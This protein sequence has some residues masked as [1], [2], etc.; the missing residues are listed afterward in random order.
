M[1]YLSM[2]V[3]FI[4]IQAGNPTPM[5]EYS[6]TGPFLSKEMCETHG[7]NLYSVALTSK[8]F[9]VTE[10]KCIINKNIKEEKGR[11]S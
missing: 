1:Y 4:L 6:Y 2:I 3:T 10:F 8:E 5:T 9:S 11:I 7:L